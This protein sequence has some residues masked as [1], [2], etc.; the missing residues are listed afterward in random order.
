M[1][2]L[3]NMYCN[4]CTHV[5]YFVLTYKLIYSM[6]I[7]YN[8]YEKMINNEQKNNEDIFYNK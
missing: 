7:T 6:N 2:I 4:K 5:L 3:Y 1:R 8:L